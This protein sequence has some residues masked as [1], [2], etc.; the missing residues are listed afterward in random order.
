MSELPGPP[1]LLPRIEALERRV[2][3]LLGLCILLGV[4]LLIEVA[5]IVAP[6]PDVVA[7]RFLLRGPHGAPRGGLLLD[8]KGQPVVRLNNAL[9]KPRVYGVVTADGRAHVW[10]ADTSY[11]ARIFLEVGPDGRTA[12][13]LCDSLG[14]AV[15]RA[16]LTSRGGL[17]LV[18]ARAAAR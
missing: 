9:G 10:L 16:D 4:G 15:L 18:P 3:R 5:W 2:R 13:G 7:S 8:E 1:D 11:R 14:A 17:T 6:Q 12:A